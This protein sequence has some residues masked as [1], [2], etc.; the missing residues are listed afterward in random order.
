MDGY[1]PSTYGDRFADVYDSWYPPGAEVDVV[2]AGLRSLAGPGPVLELGC[3][4][5]RLAIPLA[6]GG[7]TVVGIDASS[8]M[9]DLLRAK[10]APGIIA[11]E[12]DMA[13]FDVTEHGGFALAF[14]AFNTLF[15]LT[16][17][18]ALASC[19]ACVANHLAPGGRFA[20]EC[21][22]PEVDG[23]G[24]RDA[25]E[26]R[27]LTADRVV[28]RVSRHDE[29]TQTITGQHV[30]ITEAGIRLRPW[31]LR[32]ALPDELDRHAAS[33]GME[34]EDRWS[35][36]LGTPF[37]PDSPQHVSIYRLSPS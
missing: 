25:V 5:G 2:V 4:T 31:Y 32:Y 18:A 7:V 29:T 34:L 22:V 12:A 36:W 9:L 15:G 35:D 24:H 10:H 23:A 26:V 21:F 6:A 30:D 33:A 28:L 14:V 8:A 16:D 27:E 17:P 20:V 3:G 13:S 11:A 19:F 1:G 37:G